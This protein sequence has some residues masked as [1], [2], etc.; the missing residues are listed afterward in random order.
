M[1]GGIAELL[2][3]AGQL[4]EII[5]DGVP[6]RFVGHV[7]VKFRLDAGIVIQRSQ[8]QAIVVRAIIELAQDRGSAHPAKSPVIPGDDS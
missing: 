4:R 6:R 7:D 8:R 3:G 2:R 5:G 1:I